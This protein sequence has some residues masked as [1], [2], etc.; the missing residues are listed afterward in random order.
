MALTFTDICNRLKHVDEISLLEL[1][2]ITSE[3]IVDRF[4]DKIETNL[5]YFVDDLESD[6]YEM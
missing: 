5:D 2:D 4:A 6:D 3:D 1:L